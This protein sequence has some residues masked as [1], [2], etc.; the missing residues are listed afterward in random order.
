M[1]S[2]KPVL[3]MS[4]AQT[5]IHIEIS[6]TVR[7]LIQSR[8]PDSA[9]A[10]AVLAVLASDLLT[11]SD[12]WTGDEEAHSAVYDK[13]GAA[14]SIAMRLAMDAPDKSRAVVTWYDCRGANLCDLRMPLAHVE[15]LELDYAATQY[16]SKPISDRPTLS[17]RLGAVRKAQPMRFDA[18]DVSHG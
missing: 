15:T 7:M 2:G 3:Q 14:V 17:V 11:N 5:G 16:N 12:L 10:L 13:G 4:S 6:D 18:T 8:E 9:K 1:T